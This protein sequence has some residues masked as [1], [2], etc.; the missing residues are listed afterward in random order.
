MGP[1]LADRLRREWP[2][3]GAS[4]A[5]PARRSSI[6]SS[7]AH[8]LVHRTRDLARTGARGAPGALLG[9]AMF[10][11]VMPLSVLDPR[12]VRWLFAGDAASHYLGW[13]FFRSE[14]WHWPPGATWRYG[15]AMA[16]SIVYSD[17]IPLLALALKPFSAF[18]PAAFQYT[19]W[20]ILASMALTGAFGWRIG[21]VATR[22]DFGAFAAAFLA[23]LS[24]IMIDR[25]TGHYAL[26]AHWLI[27]WSLLDFLVLPRSLRA[28]GLPVWVA[29]LTH[30]Y[31]L[32]IVLAVWCSEQ[33][34]FVLQ[35][36]LLSRRRALARFVV[37][38]AAV[39]LV[40]AL[41]LQLAG[42]FE[43]SSGSIRSDMYGRFALN[44]NS[45][46]NPRWG[47]A[48]LPA[49]P[50]RAGA[51]FEGF[52]YLGLGALL[53]AASGVIG[54]IGTRSGRADMRHLWPLL[55][56]TLLLAA[57][58]LSHEV[59][60]GGREVLRIPWPRELLLRFGTFRASGRMAW[61][62]YYAV[63]M[64]GAL[65]TLRHFPHRAAV[66]IVAAA[67]I[68]QGIDLAPHVLGMRR[69]F[70]DRYERGEGLERPDLTAP[71]WEQIGAR[72]RHLHVVPMEH[73][74]PNHF[75]LG[76]F[77]ASHD[78]TI[79][80]GY[81]SRVPHLDAARASLLERVRRGDWEPETVYVLNDPTLASEIPRG[82]DDALLE[83]D[84]IWVLAPGF[85]ATRED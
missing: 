40:L 27:L 84:G 12:N 82:A 78:M 76:L 54:F 42:Y 34:R 31:L 25:A 9:V 53:L 52:A 3:E 24:P 19:G 30:A 66:P 7:V 14:P 46:L 10:I 15:E 38:D 36:R 68:L 48:F 44:L 67:V 2:L 69:F 60:L 49:L 43:L 18:L 16:S 11:A 13:F 33:L 55:A 56:T 21:K 62:L 8:R 59:F 70:T 57:F 81:F 32:L 77:A 51:E 22:S 47:S 39:I 23:V 17:S 5:P 37:R 35:H 65:S 26:M 83:R 4:G 63:L 80:V 75:S 50:A 64:G 74:A 41:V 72:Y 6:E 71:E 1:S 85:G 79:N 29:A 61:A 28:T 73:I 45:F 58:A 20:W